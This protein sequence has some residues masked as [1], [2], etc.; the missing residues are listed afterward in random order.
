MSWM[1]G[2]LQKGSGKPLKDRLDVILFNKGL[3]QSRERAKAAI[4]AGIVYVDGQRVDKA[5]T[6]VNDFQEFFIKENLCPYVSRGGLKLEKAL[7]SFDFSLEG[8]TAVDIGAST[9][10]FT[11]CMLKKG[12]KKV[13]AIDVGYGQLDYKLRIDPRVVNME[14]INIRYLD[15]E[16]IDKDVDFISIDVSFISL[17]L[18][19]PIAANLL[20]EK[21][22]LV[23]LVKPQF[24]AGREQVGKKGIIRDINVH[25]EVISNV[26]AYAESNGLYPNG[27]TFSPVTGAKGNIE[28]LLFLKKNRSNNFDAAKIINHIVSDSHDEL[29]KQ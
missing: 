14:K 11:D 28:Y 27:L 1:P 13:F 16:T 24:E 26:I 9:G 4:M 3:F 8:V 6:A 23:C 15:T 7:E 5:G 2:V 29:D 18:V 10:G 25:R 21:G 20:N 22:S 19:F 12:A 17:K